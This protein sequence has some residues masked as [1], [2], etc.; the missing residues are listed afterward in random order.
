VA[1]DPLNPFDLDIETENFQNLPYYYNALQQKC[2][3]FFEAGYQTFFTVTR[4]PKVIIYAII[5]ANINRQK[6]HNSDIIC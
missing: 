1:S 6:P 3:A 5:L 4:K 2:Q